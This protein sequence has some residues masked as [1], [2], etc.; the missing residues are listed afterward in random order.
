[1]DC[2][3]FDPTSEYSILCA[4]L[5]AG[6]TAKQAHDAVCALFPSNDE[7]EDQDDDDQDWEDDYVWVPSIV[8]T[9]WDE[10]TDFSACESYE[11]TLEDWRFYRDNFL[12]KSKAAD[13]R[14][15]FED[16]ME[17]CD[18]QDAIED[19]RNHE[20]EYYS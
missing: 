5:N 20:Q 11:P 15:T 10:N 13:D 2:C 3:I 17:W 7:G 12:R 9:N 18:I 1:M 19:D 4:L 14:Q 16:A 6:F 8:D